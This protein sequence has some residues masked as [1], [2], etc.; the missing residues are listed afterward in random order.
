MEKINKIFF[1]IMVI[2]VVGIT[3]VWS[4]DYLDGY[5]L[6]AARNNPGV[7]ARFNEYLAALEKVPQVGSLPDPQ[8]SFSYF[9][10]PVETRVGPQKAKISATQ[11]FPWFGTLGTKE[12][13]ATEIAKVKYE[14][15]REAESKLFFNIKANWYNLYF[16]KKAIDI[17]KENLDILSVFR[18]LSVIK[19]EAGLASTV[20]VLRVEMEISDLEN[21]LAMLKDKYFAQ[22]AGFNNLLNVDEYSDVMIPDS[23]VATNPEENREAIL[24]SIRNGNHSILRL[25]HLENSFKDDEQVAQKTGSPSVMLGVDYMI[26]GKSSNPMTDASESGKDGIVFPMVG[27]TIPIY[28]KKYNAM[29]KE[30]RLMQESSKN[31]RADKV[32]MLES[33]YEIVNKDYRDATRRIPLFRLQTDRAAKALRIL[34]AD[35]ETNG[36]NFEEVLRVERQLLK[37]KLE[38]E[39]ART[40][41]ETAL[42]YID[43]LMGE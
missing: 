14:E 4:Q 17:T 24:D 1:L 3:E 7:K 15:F 5:L 25:N 29:V 32:N 8:I 12:D 23:I 27:I 30:A 20:D 36:K 2:L 31:K 11:M 21:Q 18:K 43:L 9:I 34:L 10:Q 28:R 35:Y 26:T 6:E 38:L 19:V 42:A 41:N 40:D 22:Q 13:A 37:Y 16:T 39:K 33:V